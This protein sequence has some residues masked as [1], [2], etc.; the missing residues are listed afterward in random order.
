MSTAREFES[1]TSGTCYELLRSYHAVV[2]AALNP[3]ST[4]DAAAV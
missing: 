3:M 1:V 4:L 2:W